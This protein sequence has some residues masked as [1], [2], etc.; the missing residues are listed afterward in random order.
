M[1]LVARTKQLNAVCLTKKLLHSDKFL[2]FLFETNLKRFRVCFR[3]IEK[4]S[5]SFDGYF[6]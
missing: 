2:R 6:N 5:K 3:C 1:T 4:L